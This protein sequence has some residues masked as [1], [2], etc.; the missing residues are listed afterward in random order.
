MALPL[1]LRGHEN[2]ATLG[3]TYTA[4]RAFFMYLTENGHRYALGTL[5][6][7]FVQERR[8]IRCRWVLIRY[9]VPNIEQSSPNAL[10]R[11]VLRANLARATENYWVTFPLWCSVALACPWTDLHWARTRENESLT[12]QNTYCSS[13]WPDI[14][15]QPAAKI[16]LR[17]STVPCH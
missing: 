10:N 13:L 6:Q 12:P 9:G 1:T 7:R 11:E 4:C 17:R 5:L 15:L 2:I 3:H 8:C 14:R 16:L